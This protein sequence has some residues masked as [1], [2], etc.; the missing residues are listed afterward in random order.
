MVDLCLHVR[1]KYFEEI[2]AGKKKWEYRR[3]SPYW[4]NRIFDQSKGNYGRIII[5]DGYPPKS[6]YPDRRLVFSP[7]EILEQTITHPEFGPDPV[8]VIAIEL[9]ELW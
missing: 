1:R 2:K 6:E 9:P 7:G 5:Y 3:A 8:N 4:T